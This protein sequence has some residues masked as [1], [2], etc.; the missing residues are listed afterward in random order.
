M[1]VVGAREVGG[2]VGLVVVVRAEPG[3]TIAV[4][5]TVTAVITRERGGERPRARHASSAPAAWR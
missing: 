4:V 5:I 3:A 1:V 2:V